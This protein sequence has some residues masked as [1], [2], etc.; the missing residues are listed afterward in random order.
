M[1]EEIVEQIWSVS[2]VYVIFTI[3]SDTKALEG[4]LEELKPPPG[5][6]P[7]NEWN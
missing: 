5:S 3:E 6:V 1:K 7:G 4:G 2:R